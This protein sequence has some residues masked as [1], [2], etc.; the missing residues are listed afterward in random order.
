MK[1]NDYSAITKRWRA[2]RLWQYAKEKGDQQ[3]LYWADSA[4]PGFGKKGYVIPERLQTLLLGCFRKNIWFSLDASGDVEYIG[5]YEHP[6][7]LWDQ[8][9]ETLLAELWSSFDRIGRAGQY[10]HFHVRF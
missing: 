2:S 4:D 10:P 3:E 6:M 5:Y 9:S 7:T 8:H 1:E